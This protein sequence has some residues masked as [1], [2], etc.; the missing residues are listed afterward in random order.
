MAK[1]VNNE[2]LAHT[3]GACFDRGSDIGV[4][5]IEAFQAT[6]ATPLA[7]KMHTLKMKEI[8]RNKN[9][10]LYRASGV[11]TC[12]DLVERAFH[13]FIS[14]SRENYSG[15]FFEAI[16]QIFSGGIKPVNGG[17]VDL[18]VR[19][20]DTAY[21]YAMKS[22]AKGFNSSSY[23]KAKRDLLTAERRLRQDRIK[24]EKRIAFA[25]GKRRETDKDGIIQLTSKEFWAE[26]SGDPEFY[27]KL[28]DA[29]GL[30]SHLYTVDIQAPYSALLDE[31]HALFCDGD[32][33]DWNRVLKLVS[34]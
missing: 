10:Y 9:P 29:C 26:I 11:N 5:V 23:D 30:M 1:I 20:G 31:A 8:I 33:V 19:R 14:S 25:Y 18:D 27:R 3:V 7:K 17:E 15:P 34:N 16:A 12:S 24:T 6:I 21:L 22:G 13:D 32:S 4:K 28:L 2:E